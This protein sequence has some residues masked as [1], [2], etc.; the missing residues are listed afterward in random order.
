MCQMKMCQMLGADLNP[1]SSTFQTF[2]E[3]PINNEKIAIILDPCHMD[4]LIRNTWA[5]KGAIYN[6]NGKK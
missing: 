6:G 2:F 4:K 1:D 3:N 5:N